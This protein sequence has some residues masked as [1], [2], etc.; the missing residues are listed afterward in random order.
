MNLSI[1]FLVRTSL[2]AAILFL[3]MAI[4]AFAYTD[5]SSEDQGTRLAD[6]H[7]TGS[8]WKYMDANIYS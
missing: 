6:C 4:N 2:A 8:T 1:R 7:L 3:T 5:M